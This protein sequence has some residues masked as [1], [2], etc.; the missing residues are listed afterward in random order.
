MLSVVDLT[1]NAW[2]F[3][4]FLAAMLVR[5]IIKDRIALRMFNKALEDTEPAERPKIIHA[6][7][8]LI[9]RNMPSQ[10][11]DDKE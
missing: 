3:A 5:L 6:M 1:S 2:I 4:I 7:R 8:G 11:P 10:P 9:G